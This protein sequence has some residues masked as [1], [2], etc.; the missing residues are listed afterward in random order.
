[1]TPQPD[2]V[3]AWLQKASTDLLSARI[4]LEHTPPVLET[5]CFHCQQDVEKVLKAFL[6][7]QAAPF[8]KVH[9]LPYLLDLCEV[10]DPVWASLRERAETLAPYAVEVRYPSGMTEIPPAEAAETLATAEAV[11]EFALNLLPSELSSPLRRNLYTGPTQDWYT[12]CTLCTAW[13]KARR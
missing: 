13:K 9:S 10:Q 1:M 5:A 4:L 8:E 6:V 3:Q 11:W 12:C 7:W 2:E